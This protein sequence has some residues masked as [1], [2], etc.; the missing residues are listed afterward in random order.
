MVVINI[1]DV[2]VKLVDMIIV[3]GM[4]Y[5]VMA[6]KAMVEVD[7][8]EFTMK[9]K[10]YIIV[11]MAVVEVVKEPATLKFTLVLV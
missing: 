2:K 6:D 8:K 7:I 5:L 11:S 3:D 9:M 10:L 1:S 4:V